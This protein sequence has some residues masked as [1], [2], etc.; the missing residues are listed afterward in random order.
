MQWEGVARETVW[1]LIQGVWQL[2]PAAT[3]LAIVFEA[4]GGSCQ[5]PNTSVSP[6]T[7][8]M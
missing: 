3:A 5:L 8:M 2:T 1:T 4:V 6:A 7:A